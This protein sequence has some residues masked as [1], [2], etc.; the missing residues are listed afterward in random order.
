MRLDRLLSQV[1]VLDHR[2]DPGAVDVRAVSHDTRAVEPGALFCCLPGTVSDGHDHAEAA[3]GAGAVALL[4]ERYLPLDVVQVRV[5][6]ARAAMAP[7]AATLHG[8]PSL[9]LRVAGV[10]GTNGKTTTTHLLRAALEAHGWPT[11]VIGTLGGSRTTPEAPELQARLASALSSGHEA[12]AVEVSSH[13]LVQHR[14]DAVRFAVAA[15]TNL[16]RDHL[17]YHGDMESYFKAK[18]TL[19]ERGRSACGVVNADDPYGRR[20][21]DTASIPVRA[22]SL[23]DAVDLEVGPLGTSFRWEGQRVT[24]ALGGRFNAANA[25]CAATVA[26]ELGVPADA[27]AAGLS[28][29]RSVP[30]RY[31]RVDAGQPFTVVVDYAHTPDALAQVLAAARETAGPGRVILVFGCGG[32]RDRTKRPLMGQTASNLA[33]VAILTSDNPRGEDPGSIIDEVRAGAR[34]RPLHVEE[35][36]RRAIE[37]AVRQA[38][39]HDVVVIAGKGHETGQA[40]AGAT[41][42]F[43]DRQVA[44]SALEAG[45]AGPRA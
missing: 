17:D 27:V 2:G 40:L 32:E 34:A 29:V 10:T 20:L 18:A 9:Y 36:R 26:R 24:L 15:F 14:V 35:D 42:P 30:G 31:E 4:V 6:D 43:D 12:A 41:V 39:P 11:V 45:Q 3:V 13:A 8:C 5:A 44:R 38:R 7:V 22:Y 23:A 16:G 33:D 21:L 28:S 25:V 1:E 37:L 19:F